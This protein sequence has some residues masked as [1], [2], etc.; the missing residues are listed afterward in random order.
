METNV[1]TV[2]HHNAFKINIKSLLH[3]TQ[4]VFEEQTTLSS[5]MTT[6]H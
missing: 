3:Y 1:V 5:K 2:K 6:K 4:S